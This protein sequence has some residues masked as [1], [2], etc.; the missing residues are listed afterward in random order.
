[1]KHVYMILSDTTFGLRRVQ[2]GE[3]RIYKWF[4]VDAIAKLSESF[5]K[6]SGES[7]VI[8]VAEHLSVLAK[9]ANSREVLDGQGTQ[10]IKKRI[11]CAIKIMKTKLNGK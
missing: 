8:A 2:V 5:R 4:A 11:A 10:I 1:M 9:A 3:P 6:P 7:N